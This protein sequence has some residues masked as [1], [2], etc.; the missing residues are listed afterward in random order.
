M[1]LQELARQVYEMFETRTRGDGSSFDTLKEAGPA[2][3]PDWVI[4][5]IREAHDDEL[6]NDWRYSAVRAAFEAIADGTTIDDAGE[7]ADGMVDVYNSDRLRWVAD[8][9]GRAELCDEA[10]E[11]MGSPNATLID[12]I[13]LGQ[14]VTLER[15]FSTIYNACEEAAEASEDID[16]NA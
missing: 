1:E 7:W 8:Y 10:A 13:G 15:I 12:R 3:T 11:E 5:A 6:P 2:H 14:Y 16:E 4:D 9:G